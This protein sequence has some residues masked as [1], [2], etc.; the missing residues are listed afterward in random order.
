M[1]TAMNQGAI[2]PS[3][4][5]A[6]VK[7]SVDPEIVATFKAACAASNVSMTAELSR[8]MVDY[9][10]GSVKSKVAPNYSTRRHRRTAIK[11]MIKELEQIRACEEKVRDNT[12]ENLQESSAYEATEEAISMLDE[13]IDILAEF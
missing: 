12:P 8:F 10:K 13:V 7:V 4:Q 9:V 6:Q 2:C 5:L 11:T 3:A 1:K